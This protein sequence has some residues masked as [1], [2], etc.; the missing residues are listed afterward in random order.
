MLRHR[1][2]ACGSKLE[3]VTLRQRPVLRLKQARWANCVSLQYALVIP[4]RVEPIGD[5]V[6]NI[7]NML[8]M[9]PVLLIFKVH[10]LRLARTLAPSEGM[11]SCRSLLMTHKMR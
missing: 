1:E 9:C 3:G 6:L 5:T 4:G 11:N 7:F 2:G 8:C 10:A